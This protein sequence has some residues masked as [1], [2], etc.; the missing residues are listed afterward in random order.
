M[1]Q[2]ELARAIH[3]STAT[4]ASWETDRR[5]PR[6]SARSKIIEAADLL[7]VPASDLNTML[8]DIGQ[9]PV[10]ARRFA[11]VRDRRKP[12]AVL[13]SECRSY[14]WPT[15]AMNE[16]FEVIAWNDAANDLSELDF[17]TDLAEPGARHLLRMAL[18]D[19]YAA[20]LQNW[21]DVI[22]I[23]V[24][25][26]KTTGFDPMSPEG[27]TPYFENLMAF[28]FTHHTAEIGRL[29]NIWQGTTPHT[30]GQRVVFPARWR[31]SDGTQLCFNCELSGWSDFDAVAA[32]DWH[33][34][35]A[36]TWQWLEAR[37]ASRASA[38]HRD[39]AVGSDVRPA[40]ARELLRDARQRTGLTQRELS[41]RAGLSKDLVYSLEAGRK[42]MVESTLL[43]LGEAMALNTAE[44]NT[45]LD[46]AGFEPR[47]SDQFQY[48][49]GYNVAD[50][51]RYGATLERRTNWTPDAITREIA[52][53]RWPVIVVNERCEVMC[54]NVPAM[55][56]MGAA[57][58][59]LGSGPERNLFALVTD[60]PFRS[61]VPNWE[62][63]VANVLPGNL[64]AYMAPPGPERRLAK[65]E[66]YFASVVDFVR[67]REARAGR[68]DAVIHAAFAAWRA[69]PGRKLS[70]RVAFGL[71]WQTESA[72][73]SFDTVIMPWDAMRDPYWSIE[74]HP[75]NASTWKWLE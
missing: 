51:V 75:G 14:K 71:E 66:A 36:L 54:S 24:G 47:A 50:N 23:M 17:G 56:V 1:S 62:T 39:E 61:A 73:L 65:D 30:E 15:L 64:E 12:L 67:S 42:P 74:L 45:L 18:S 13:E 32:L 35:D 58:E 29:L 31:T 7:G 20:K 19:H 26:W 25:M 11:P 69:L 44:L 33:P 53:Y 38:V 4:I 10:P 2:V 37:R 68:G 59:G 55:R 5:R 70:A 72:R 34:A 9:P 6:P 41:N 27:R 48:I 57:L 60:A 46:A 22:G 8:V 49:L 52:T 28:V 63:V 3:V 16:D 40:T 21:D 43:Q